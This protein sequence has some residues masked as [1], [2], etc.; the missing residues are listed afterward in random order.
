MRTVCCSQGSGG[1][2]IAV[3]QLVP[4]RSRSLE[5]Y[6]L[7]HVDKKQVQYSVLYCIC[8]VGRKLHA[9]AF[10]QYGCDTHQPR[11]TSRCVGARSDRMTMLVCTVRA[12][13]R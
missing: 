2:R 9:V 8:S 3:V 12:L 4:Q 5:S 13:L 10:I 1:F 11:V 7:R 6:R